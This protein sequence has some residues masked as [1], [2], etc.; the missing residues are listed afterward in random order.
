MTD[1]D[2]TRYHRV[3][4]PQFDWGQRVIARLQPSGGQRILDHDSKTSSVASALTAMR[5]MMNSIGV[6][7]ATS[8]SQNNRPFSMP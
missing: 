7:G 5:N 6:A 1:W 4:E 3:S 2:A 8:I